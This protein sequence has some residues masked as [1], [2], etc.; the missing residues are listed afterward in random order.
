MTLDCLLI[1]KNIYHERHSQKGYKNNLQLD[2]D[3]TDQGQTRLV[4]E[5]AFRLRLYARC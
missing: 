5:N 1:K 3:Q 4:L 2:P